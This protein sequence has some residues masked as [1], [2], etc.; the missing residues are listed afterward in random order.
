MPNIMVTPVRYEMRQGHLELL[1]KVHTPRGVSWRREHDWYAPPDVT[2]GQIC[3]AV[4]NYFGVTDVEF[5]P[6]LLP[7]TTKEYHAGDYLE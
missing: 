6:P 7:L 5:Q 4:A 3:E 2:V 1:L